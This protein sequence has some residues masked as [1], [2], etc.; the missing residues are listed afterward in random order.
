MKRNIICLCLLIFI[1]LSGCATAHQYEFSFKDTLSV[2]ILKNEDNYFFCIPVQYMGFYQIEKFDFNSGYILT[3]DYEILLKRDEINIFIYLNEEADEYG[4]TDGV[5]NLIYSE[6]KG[7]ILFS[8]M[9][10]PLAAKQES[11]GIMNYY[12]IFIERYIDNE[13]MKEL[14]SEYE[15]GKINSRFRIEYNLVIDNEVQNGNSILDDFELYNGT[16]IDPFWFPSN[17]DFFK[18]KYIK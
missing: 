15:K 7:K 17:L 5:F 2:F 18:A 1:F 13:E 8:K 10:E 6:E 9:D 3:G 12:Y 14:T 4:N 16:A 11:G